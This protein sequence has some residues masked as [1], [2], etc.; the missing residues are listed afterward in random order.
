MF[1]EHLDELANQRKLTQSV[2][3]ANVQDDGSTAKKKKVI[4]SKAK[5]RSKKL[6]TDELDDSDGESDIIQYEHQ[7]D[8]FKPAVKSSK[9][10]LEL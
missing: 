9:S 8:A 3:T 2:A 1:K 4:I 5:P 6:E 10:K 7:S